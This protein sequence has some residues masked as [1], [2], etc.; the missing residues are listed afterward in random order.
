MVTRAEINKAKQQVEEAKTQIEESRGQIQTSQQ[1]VQEELTKLKPKKRVPF[2]PRKT[3]YATK[4]YKQQLGATGSELKSAAEQLTA[5]EA[6]VLAY[7]KQV[8]AADKALK[9]VEEYNA[10]VRTIEKAAAKGMVWAH[11]AYGT[12]L[13]RKLAKQYL[14]RQALLKESFRDQIEKFQQEN[15]SEKLLVDWKNMKV[16]GVESGALQQS[17]S[18]DNYNKRIA[19]L[20]K[21][22]DTSGYK[23]YEKELPAFYDPLKGQEVLQSIA[24]DIAEQRGL[25]PINLQ[26]YN[27]ETG[28][29]LA[30]SKTGLLTPQQ[31][32]YQQLMAGISNLKQVETP[33][34]FELGGER[35]QIDT[36]ELLKG[37]KTTYE[38]AAMAQP[39]SGK[40]LKAIQY[41]IDPLAFEQQYGYAVDP[42]TGET[43]AVAGT[44]SPIINVGPPRKE[45]ESFWKWYGRNIRDPESTQSAF[46][47][48]LLLTG[49]R[50]ITAGGK[51]TLKAAQRSLG[52]ALSE[53]I[54]GLSFGAI[55]KVI[56]S[57]KTGFALSGAPRQIARGL[58]I[59]ATAKNPTIAAAYM[60]NLSKEA[61]KDPKGVV[62]AMKDYFMESPYELATVAVAGKA[63]L[64]IRQRL[65]RNQLYYEISGNLKKKY[66]ANSIELKEF[67]KAWTRAF[68][69]LPKKVP[70]TKTYT[71]KNLQAVAR[72]DAKIV[73]ILDSVMSK[74]GPEVIGS[75][76][77]LPQTT[78]TKLPRGK[79]GDIDVQQVGFWGRKSGKMAY[80]IY[81]KLKKAGYNVKIKEGSF[82][83]HKKYYITLD[84]KELVN[85][86][87]SSDYFISTQAGP[88]RNLFESKYFG[89]W[90]RDP[91]TGVKLSP[92]R[93][94][95]RVKIAKGYTSGRA[96]DVVDVSGI[97]AGTEYLFSPS[98]K[99][100]GPKVRTS[101]ADLAAGAFEMITSPIRNINTALTGGGQGAAG[102]YYGAPIKTPTVAYLP[103][104]EDFSDYIAPTK[105]SY[106]KPTYKKP[107]SY[108]NPLIPS[109]AKPP[110]Y[111][112]PKIQY[113]K[114]SYSNLLV[115]TYKAPQYKKP[116]MPKYQKPAKYQ[117]PFAPYLAVAWEPTTG[118][119]F[120]ITQKPRKQP[121]PVKKKKKKKPT[122]KTLPTLSQ[123]LIGY[124]GKRAIERPTG[125]EAIRII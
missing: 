63:E 116:K 54:A 32:A 72:G 58:L 62:T 123:Q 86:G 124:R 112:T 76:V 47:T 34:T 79:M 88:L 36:L 1:K 122:Y 61:V 90:T 21:S 102:Y 89:Q 93:A 2:T 45:G 64:R 14:K 17:L 39:Y 68:K 13:V 50:G 44:V 71:T 96:K 4:K 117:D 30:T 106:P 5:S 70:I 98:G 41:A 51:A 37:P 56:P 108:V 105:Q 82:Y 28:K 69:Q 110:T 19:E 92:I 75:S 49:A 84:G 101:P 94:Q 55:E 77:I 113:K 121:R 78:L 22:L 35:K 118:D 114:A 125:F 46:N 80:E 33:T 99:Y 85:I 95:L 81:S 26:A 87:T 73:K 97:V 20:N 9:E 52:I 12:G 60:S 109:Y 27:Q 10:A 103:P 65:A 24:P 53:P 38:A 59:Y 107:S 100:I 111:E 8:K 40:R 15:P 74:Y 67:N 29:Y 6:D 16:T 25:L 42:I 83:G 31:Q 104:E 43:T 11:A 48:A 3:R 7:E 115:P 119:I 57:K 66:G 120:T 23:F 91:V 18:L